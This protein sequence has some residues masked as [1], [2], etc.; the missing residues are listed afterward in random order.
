MTSVLITF[1][2]LSKQE[3]KPENGMFSNKAI[4]QAGK[5]TKRATVPDCW[6]LPSFRFSLNKIFFF[7]KNNFMLFKKD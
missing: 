1:P 5:E 6:I 4:A 2:C 3:T 7:F